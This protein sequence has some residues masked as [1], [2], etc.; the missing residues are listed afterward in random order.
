MFKKLVNL[1]HILIHAIILTVI[2][3][4]IIILGLNF[5]FAYF[6]STQPLFPEK[7]TI[8]SSAESGS[9]EPASS[10]NVNTHIRQVLPPQSTPNPVS[11]SQQELW[12]ALT[13][14]RQTHDRNSLVFEE[15]LCK[16][17]RARVVEHQ[18]RFIT[19]SPDDN[20]LDNHA[21]FQRD[22]DSGLVFETT[23]FNTVAEV[24][25]YLPNA[26][27]ATQVIEWGWDSSPAHREGLLSNDSTHA[28][29]AGTAPFFV[30]ILG[31]R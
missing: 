4:V 28:C 25:A 13:I 24:L 27:N 16:Y 8:P 17:A 11:I 14:Y 7:I 12:N 30:G 18:N 3:L 21:G 9:T 10:P 6:Q 15:N 26:Q 19:I 23:N 5:F 1:L 31:T 29:L 20:P 2:S 22:A